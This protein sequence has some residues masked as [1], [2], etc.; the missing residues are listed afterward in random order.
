MENTNCGENC[1][2]VKSG[3]CKSDCECPFYVE[4]WWIKSGEQIP[5]KI[6][7]CH[8][9]R[10]TIEINN[11]HQRLVAIQSVQEETR[12]RLANLENLLSQLIAESK[13]FLSNKNE[14][15]LK[16]QNN[17]YKKIEGQS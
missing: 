11:Q 14:E 5:V 4:S 12:N 10:S 8:T 17:E 16:L 6:K 9:K 3:F 1:A 15:Q 13:V 2:F 7:D